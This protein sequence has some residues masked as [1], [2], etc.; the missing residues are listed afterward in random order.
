MFDINMDLDLL[1]DVGLQAAPDQAA[2]AAMQATH[3]TSTATAPQLATPRLGSGGQ[4]SS[5]SGGLHHQSVPH[6]SDTESAL[7][8]AQLAAEG[9]LMEGGAAAVASCYGADSAAA[10]PPQL[11]EVLGEGGWGGGG[12][13][14]YPPGL[15]PPSAHVCVLMLM[16]VLARR[17]QGSVQSHTQTQGIKDDGR[18][19]TAPAD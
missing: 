2:E 7:P 13:G 1:A 9:I 5:S 16:L 15:D 18:R 6:D 10:T 17:R 19:A 12:G 4:P 14:L 8:D 11:G 3:S